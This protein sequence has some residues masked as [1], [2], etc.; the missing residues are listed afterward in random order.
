MRWG[1][2]LGRVKP[3]SG[4]IAVIRQTIEFAP[5]RADSSLESPD[6]ITLDIE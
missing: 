3:E 4:V 5:H 6:T 2:R 1:A